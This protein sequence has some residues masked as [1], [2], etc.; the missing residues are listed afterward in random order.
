M[1]RL[2]Q[3]RDRTQGLPDLLNFA[4][5]PQDGILQ[6]KDGSLTVSWYFRGE[7]MDSAT[8]SELAG[9]SPRLN[10]ILVGLGNGWMLNC[11]A[12]RKPATTYPEG[13]NFPD[14]TTWLIDEERPGQYEAEGAHFETT[15]ALSLTYLP[16][17]RAS[18]KLI[19]MIY[20]DDGR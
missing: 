2:K 14:H 1:L 15:Y 11:D 9:I 4:L 19:E 18:N 17:L 16:P 13:S 3:F 6:N 7:D 10:G 12:I 5:L 8:H 20:E